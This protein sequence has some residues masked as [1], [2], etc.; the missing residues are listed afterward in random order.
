MALTAGIQRY[1]LYYRQKR[2]GLRLPQV[3]RTV[4]MLAGHCGKSVRQNSLRVHFGITYRC[5]C[6]CG[7]CGIGTHPV[8]PERE[9]S[10]GQILGLLRRIADLPSLSTVVSFFGGEP[11][12]RDGIYAFVESA[13]R[14]GL[15]TELE[16]NG[17]L[18]T[19][20]NVKRLKRSALHH[21]IVNIE[22]C[23][24]GAHDRYVRY[25]G[26]FEKATEGIRQCVRQG[27]PCTLS[28]IAMREK[29]YNKDLEKTIAMG[30][31]LGAASIRLLYP[32]LIG[33]WQDAQERLLTDDEKQ[34]VMGLLEPDFIYL[35]STNSSKIKIGRICAASQK[36]LFY[37]SPYGE[38]QPC[39]GVPLRFGML[40]D[41]GDL[42]GL[43]GQMWGSCIFQQERGN[44]CLMH[45][46]DI[47]RLLPDNTL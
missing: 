23:S 27:I 6:K 20:E 13:H 24:S 9:L 35:E 30:R 12:L 2:R 34:Y 14:L 7:C 39:F 25:E 1:A 45:Q 43:V 37:I 33:N 17:I 46:A 5:Q 26:G 42:A 22:S 44:E 41:G 36:K 16:T 11:L 19:P 4:R 29:I 18:L 10:D 8:S 32:T 40:S 38:L 15:F 3:S 21:I 31:Q 28:T 47:R